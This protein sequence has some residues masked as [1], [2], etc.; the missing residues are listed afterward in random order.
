MIITEVHLQKGNL[1]NSKSDADDSQQILTPRFLFK[2]PWDHS[3]F[4]IA[5]RGRIFYGSRR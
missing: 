1:G 2:S 4:E 5:D 3:R